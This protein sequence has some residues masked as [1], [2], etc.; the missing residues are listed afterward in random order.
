M[1]AST[2]VHT[3][4]IELHVFILQTIGSNLSN[5]EYFHHPL[6]KAGL[7]SV[8]NALFCGLAVAEV[9]IL[10]QAT[11]PVVIMVIGNNWRSW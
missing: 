9:F 7:C 4:H 3:R 11:H 8:L 1:L 2:G 10:S 6:L 5:A